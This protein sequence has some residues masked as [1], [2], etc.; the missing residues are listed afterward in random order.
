M[1]SQHP[2]HPEGWA[3]ATTDAALKTALHRLFDGQIPNYASYNLVCA[4]ET[5][6]TFD[7]VLPGA[8]VPH[9]LVLG[10][11]RRP[12]ELVI[13]PFDRRTLEPSGRPWTIDL[14]NL[15]YAEEAV[16]GAFDIGTSTGR[17]YS[18]TVRGRCVIDAPSSPHP[19]VIEQV[20]DAEDFADFM[21]TLAAL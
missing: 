17:V 7:G 20:D 18:F 21:R 5:G 13:T 12:A 8:P 15:A 11:R 14:T 6:G 3:R 9:G 16:P 10:Y 19:R 4:A 2:P 1:S